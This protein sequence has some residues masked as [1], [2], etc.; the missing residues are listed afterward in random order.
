M[1]DWRKQK[2]TVRHGEIWRA[3]G[4]TNEDDA[5]RQP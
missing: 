2:K 4:E 5:P 3:K 1:V